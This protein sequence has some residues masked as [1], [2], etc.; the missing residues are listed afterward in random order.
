MEEEIKIFINLQV[1]TTIFR[2]SRKY[3]GET[4]ILNNN[5]NNNMILT[6]EVNEDSSMHKKL[7]NSNSH[8]HPV[9]SAKNIWF[10]TAQISYPLAVNVIKNDGPYEKQAPLTSERSPL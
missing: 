2:F 8:C 7:Q 1:K 6:F 10:Y 3:E 9:N 4:R 5:N